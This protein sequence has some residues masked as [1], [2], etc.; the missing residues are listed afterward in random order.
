MINPKLVKKLE[1]KIRS[2]SII[3][4]YCFDMS[5]ANEDFIELES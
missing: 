3:V 1:I 2:T 5:I 4:S